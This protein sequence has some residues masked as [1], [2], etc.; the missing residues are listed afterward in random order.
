MTGSHA[1]RI[2]AI[3]GGAVTRARTRLVRKSSAR[4]AVCRFGTMRRSTRSSW[5]S[6]PSET[7]W[8]SSVMPVMPA[9]GSACSLSAVAAP[10]TE[11]SRL[12]R[13]T[14]SRMSPAAR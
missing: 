4:C 2:G 8:H 10:F 3:R 1:A 9:C 6:G 12:A 7:W 14:T 11:S 13:P 5:V